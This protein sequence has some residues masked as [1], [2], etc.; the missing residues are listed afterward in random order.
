MAF[1]LD[2]NTIYNDATNSL[3]AIAYQEAF[4]R[5]MAAD[6]HLEVILVE[7]GTW[8][9]GAGPGFQDVVLL[10]RPVGSGGAREPG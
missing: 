1:R 4:V 2:E 6:A 9:G 8:A 10:R 7:R 5:E 3:R